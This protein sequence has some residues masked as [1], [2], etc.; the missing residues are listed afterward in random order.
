[1]DR[2]HRLAAALAAGLVLLTGL[3]TGLLL[4][5]ADLPDEERG[6]VFI[7]LPP[8]TEP[9]PLVARAG[10]GVIRSSWLPNGWLAYSEETGFARRLRLAGAWWVLPSEAFEPALTGGCGFTTFTWRLASLTREQTLKSLGRL[11]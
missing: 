9:V 8:G 3:I 2:P 7:I 1:M 5:Q 6:R 11:D 10:G 4:T